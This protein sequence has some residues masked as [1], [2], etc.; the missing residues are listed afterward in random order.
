M[1]SQ[2][3][4]LESYN[5]LN[6]ALCNLLEGRNPELSLS[7]SLEY[8][9]LILETSSDSVGFAIANG[10]PK[11]TVK[12]AYESFKQLYRQKHESWKERNLSFVI[13]RSE[14]EPAHDA[15]FSSFETDIYFCRKYIIRLRHNQ[16][17]L[18]SELLQLPFLPLNESQSPGLLRP[19]SAQTLLQSINVASRLARQIIVP[20]VSSAES[21]VEQLINDKDT[22]YSI[23]VGSVP[24]TELQ[25]TPTDRI[26]IK[27]VVIEAFR[28][29]KKMYEFDVDADVVVLYGPNGLG[30]TS[31][32][33]AIDYV[34]T[35]RIGRLCRRR[36]NH[37]D[38][39]DLVRHLGAPTREGHVSIDVSHK[40]K[41]QLLRRVVTDWGSAWVDKEK[42]DRAKTLQFLTDSRWGQK[43]ARIENLERLFRA[44]HLFGQSDPEFLVEFEYDSTLSSDLVHR[45][46]ALDDYATGLAKT[47]SILA[48][49]EKKLVKNTQD[50]KSLIDQQKEVKSKI[51]ALPKNQE[52]G[53]VGNEVKEMAAS[54]VNDLRLYTNFAI[55]NITPDEA[56]TRE[57]RAMS[58]SA[59]KDAQDKVNELTNIESEF[60]LY[61][62][63]KSL[64]K[65]ISEDISKLES[66]V[67]EKQIAEQKCHNQKKE[68][69]NNLEKE[70]NTL[71]LILRRINDLTEM[72]GLQEIFK[73]TQGSL[74]Q[75]QQELERIA[76]EVDR[77]TSQLKPLLPMAENK[78]LRTLE[79]HDAVRKSNDR[80]QA[81]LTFQKNLPL[82]ETNRKSIANLKQTIQNEKLV[83]QRAKDNIEEHKG[84]IVAQ[85]QI[86][87]ASEKE[88]IIYSNSQLELTQFLD[89]I[90]SHI[91]NGI[92][93]TCGTDH[94]SRA[95]LIEKIQSQKEVR[96]AHVE[97]I[98]KR[99][100]E[101]RIS[102]K[103]EIDLVNESVKDHI[104]M[105]SK[106]D[107]MLKH[108][109]RLHNDIDLF[110]RSVVELGGSVNSD[111]VM[112]AESELRKER[113]ALKHS[114][115]AL[116]KADSELKNITEQINKFDQILTQLSTAKKRAEIEIIPLKQQLFNIRTKSESSGISIN[117]SPQE[118]TDEKD[119]L[120][121]KKIE[122]EKRISELTI[123]I[124]KITDVKKS[125]K[126][127]LTEA[128]EKISAL[129]E[130]KNNILNKL[131]RYEERASF[132]VHLSTLTATS[133][134]NVKEKASH[135]L[136]I[137]EALRRRCLT[138]ERMVDAALRS[139]LLAD[140]EMQDQLMVIRKQEVE[141]EASRIS[142]IKKY[143]TSVKEALDKQSTYAVDNHVKAF[144]P[145]TSLIQ[146]RLRT[147][148]GFG[149]IKLNAKGKEINVEVGWANKLL[150]PTDYFSDSQKQ[151]LM[152]SLFLAGRLTQ[153]WSGFAPIFL[154]DPVTHFDDLNA[155]GFVE[156]IRGLTS[157]APGKRQ[158]LI[159]TCEERLFDLMRKKFSNIQGGAKYYR[160]K[161]IGDDGPIIETV[162]N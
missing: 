42:L 97:A 5:R 144:G 36:I 64:L 89:K 14:H 112:Y 56:S 94:K 25:G 66:E 26:R 53:I 58:E 90:E 70:R 72:G 60:S 1:F 44:T 132:L 156:L 29:Y 13:C 8:P 79:L 55:S 100:S 113:I 110:E 71:S 135:H 40:G 50:T 138:L 34:C 108:F 142:Q 47:S 39:I 106:I 27:K 95:I 86:L 120:I 146:K 128:V 159:S 59:L 160:F 52:A 126:I 149:D 68:I 73:K 147:V 93:P 155:F 122:V 96:P 12:T 148:Y 125:I 51:E 45:M 88:Y 35:G 9:L 104:L 161:G 37:Q 83:E 65:H 32:F 137:I 133:I 158:F 139:A 98:A 75:S 127:Q 16:D 141:K 115:E 54:I 85:E 31:F 2:E 101:L 116:S 48:L 99:C 63:N 46:L 114:Q 33:D 134:T 131:R 78:R 87:A 57:W 76:V 91:E 30:K 143:F 92:C 17:D 151:I 22:P 69:R 38:F 136:L 130:D 28:A 80:I 43:R 105:K 119:Y 118:R 152:L 6:A 3:K 7:Q 117:I 81:L 154:D 129:H 82:W 67:K 107:N 23:T 20:L 84:N 41:S 103:N 150:K 61:D 74:Q 140:L 62:K 18:I 24:E 15:F 4:T 153:N 111:L 21:I 123:Q 11:T 49:I 145:L 121:F 162:Y 77:T 19:P 157:T 10:I 109:E 102:I 124:S